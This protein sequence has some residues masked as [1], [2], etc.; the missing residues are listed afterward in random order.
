MAPMTIRPSLWR[1]WA[2][3][4]RLPRRTV[5]L[6]LT[7]VYGCLFLVSGASLLAI[8]YVFVRSSIDGAC[9]YTTA[10]GVDEKACAVGSG[11]LPGP[12]SGAGAGNL[13]TGARSGYSITYHQRTPSSTPAGSSR[14]R[15]ERSVAAPRTS[16]ASK[17]VQQEA[18][19]LQQLADKLTARELHSLLTE[20][21]IAL[22]LMSIV[23]VVLGWLMA[24]RVLRPLRT[25]TAKA[26]KISATNLHERLALEGPDD[27]LKDLGDTFDDL[28]GRLESS[29]V[30]QRQFVANA[31]HE[32][33]TPLARQ[34]ALAQVAL[35][36]PAASVG[37]LR[38]A[39]ERI[40]VSNAQQEQLIDALLTLS[41]AQVTSAASER[42]DLAAL[43]RDLLVVK[44]AEAEL[45]GLHVDVVLAAAPVAGDPRLVER[46]MVNLF[47]NA[48]RHNV[49][50]G[51]I[52]V[53]TGT[54][55]DAS[56]LSVAND[57]PLVP[58]GEVER[59]FE[60]FER[61]AP[62]RT[63]GN[64][65]FGLGLSI[66][67]AVATL[68]GADVTA[69]PRARGGLAIEVRIPAGTTGSGGPPPRRPDP[70]GDRPALSVEGAG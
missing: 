43:A 47:D 64:E 42:F 54:R 58:A 37:S 59:L 14:S 39:H 52:E 18:A 68:H 51:G 53:V 67:R 57:G 24:G 17:G 31:S 26:Q 33:R 44:T 29:F 16:L 23:A 11:A 32:L 8:T 61:L 70:V 46:L 2:R 63:V 38:A 15:H 28:L 12:A 55:A 7:A 56:F 10:K 3:D 36:D 49:P 30:A 69:G 62:E 19:Q 45:R 40:L 1:S 41:R 22:A 66:V 4:A 21:G 35:E 25:I 65:G 20:S 13:T 9:I 5:R 27:E 6:R 50:G 60:P 48:I 34:R